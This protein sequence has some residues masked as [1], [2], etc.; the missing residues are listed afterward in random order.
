MDAADSIKGFNSP[1]I[2]GLG[3]AEDDENRLHRTAVA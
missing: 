3:V 2:L 1:L